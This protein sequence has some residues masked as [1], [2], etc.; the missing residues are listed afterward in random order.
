VLETRSLKC[1]LGRC[2]VYVY[3][4]YAESGYAANPGRVCKVSCCLGVLR[5]VMRSCAVLC[6]DRNGG[7]QKFHVTLAH[8]RA[9]TQ[10]TVISFRL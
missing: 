10:N 8:R 2:S 4:A 9:P 1:A 6:C 3:A 5:V 7:F